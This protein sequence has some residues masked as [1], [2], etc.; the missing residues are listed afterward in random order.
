MA[1]GS[2]IMRTP[3]E[4]AGGVSCSL[5]NNNGDSEEL[6]L[7]YDSDDDVVM[8][9]KET[10]VK[11]GSSK[12]LLLL[13]PP[14]KASNYKTC[15]KREGAPIWDYGGVKEPRSVLSVPFPLVL[16]METLET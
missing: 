14:S 11:G 3:K 9:T 10:V 13:H 1:Q 4:G 5:I 15:R 2:L 12:S 6:R 16:P 8:E 7:V